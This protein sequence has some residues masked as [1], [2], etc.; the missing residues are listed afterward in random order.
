MKYAVWV[1]HVD[2][3]RDERSPRPVVTNGPLQFG[4]TLPIAN[5]GCWITEVIEGEWV[6]DAGH[7]YDGRAYAAAGP[8]RDPDT[9]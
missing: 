2:G 1:T 9:E 3:R 6:D 4:D 7:V 8:H 5:V